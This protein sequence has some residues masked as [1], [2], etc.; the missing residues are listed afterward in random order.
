ML[1]THT[2]THA[3]APAC[4][5]FV[6]HQFSQSVRQVSALN[7]QNLWQRQFMTMVD[8]RADDDGATISDQASVSLSLHKIMACMCLCQWNRWMRE[9]PTDQLNPTW[10]KHKRNFISFCLVSISLESSLL[11]ARTV[12]RSV[13]AAAAAAA[14]A[15]MCGYKCSLIAQVYMWIRS[16]ILPLEETE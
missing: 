7:A 15:H 3:H 8:D 14:G 10:H 5:R 6:I 16:D 2:Q 9:A 4:I 11:V 13:S 1:R 12:G